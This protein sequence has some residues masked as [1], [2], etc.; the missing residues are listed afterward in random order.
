MIA[1]YLRVST[2]DQDTG[3]QR[4]E[5]DQWR[6]GNGIRS[7]AVTW[8]EDHETGTTL[9]RPAFERLQAD[10][11]AG[12]V[13]TVIIWKLDRISRKM[14]DGTNVLADWTDRGVRVVSV[15]QQ[16]D[17]TGVVG[18]IIASVLFG[19]AEIDLQ[20]MKDRRRA[21]IAQAKIRGVYKGRR[22]GARKADRIR[23]RE[24]QEKGLKPAEIALALGISER[25]AFRY[26]EE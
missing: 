11:F 12:K 18:R 15:T 7:D 19:L 8:Y 3:L 25:T 6:R 21:G 20:N 1:A 14:R 9:R 10:I 2:K 4:A 5:I 24:L 17:L 26:L 16:L 13:K 22:P 23:A